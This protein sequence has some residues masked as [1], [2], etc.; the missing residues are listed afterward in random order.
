VGPTSVATPGHGSIEVR[1]PPHPS[2][3]S[4]AR[5]HV[6]ELLDG[7]GRGD[8]TEATVLLVSE[9]VTNALLHAGTEIELRAGVDESGVRV[10]VGDG[11]LHF[12]SRRRYAATAGTGRGLMMLESMVDD[13]GVT[14]H[15][16]GKTVWFLLSDGSFER[17]TEPAHHPDSPEGGRPPGGGDVTVELQNMPLLLHAAWQEHAEALLREYLL[18]SL[19]STDDDPVQVHAE[20]TDAIAVLEEH[21]PGT[22]VPVVADELMTDATEPEVSVDRVRVPVPRESVAH[23]DTLDRAIEAALDL[24]EEGLVLSPVTQPEVQAFRR[25][26]CRQV[27]RQ[28]AGSRPEPWTVPDDADAALLVPPGWDPT[29]VADATRAVVAANQLSQIV[30]VSRPAAELLGYEDPADL[31]GRRIVAMIPER[32]RQAHVAGFTMFLLVGRRPL[33]ERAVTVPALRRDGSE[34]TV[35][36]SV[37]DQPLGDGH[38]VLVADLRRA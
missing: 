30:A 1:L 25:W 16:T 12:P 20:A 35:E 38:S 2:S 23:F 22:P 21:L 10:E 4:V 13:W 27:L 14:T 19:D 33:L 36:L 8:L 3:V 32:F 26:L 37:H 24:S 15:A 6:R 31:V 11:S 5:R 29:A 17:D 7:A 28:A 9:V 34:V 18:A